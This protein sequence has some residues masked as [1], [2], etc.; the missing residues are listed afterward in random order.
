MA[1]QNLLFKFPSGMTSGL[2]EIKWLKLGRVS[3]RRRRPFHS[4]QVFEMMRTT[5]R[6]GN[7]VIPILTD[8]S[9][10]G[11]RLVLW[12][13]NNMR[14]RIKGWAPEKSDKCSGVRHVSSTEYRNRHCL[15]IRS[16][17]SV[18]SSMTSFQPRRRIYK[19]D[20]GDL[21]APQSSRLGTEEK[22]SRRPGSEIR[23]LTQL[24]NFFPFFFRI[25]LERQATTSQRRP[26]AR[27]TE[28]YVCRIPP[29]SPAEPGDCLDA[30]A[31]HPGTTSILWNPATPKS[32]PA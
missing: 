20:I 5:N 28:E 12:M 13:S 25:G 26:F 2:V 19:W 11:P 8:K 16:H 21:K 1:F 15:E 14:L 7:Q 10:D 24:N 17:P 18:L 27:D 29:W 3:G 32:G 23:S 9:A 4:E 30:V 22:R 31:F 6:L